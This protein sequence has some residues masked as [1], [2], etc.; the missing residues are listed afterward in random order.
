MLGNINEILIVLFTIVFGA[1]AGVIGYL[2]RRFNAR[3]DEIIVLVEKD[4]EE[5]HKYIIKSEHRITTIETHLKYII[6]KN[7]LKDE[8]E[9]DE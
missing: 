9:E 7:G 4:K 1:W 8:N 3:L 5:V 2:G 6:R